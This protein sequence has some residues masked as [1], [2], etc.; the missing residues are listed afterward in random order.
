MKNSILIKIFLQLKMVIY[1]EACESGS[2]FED[3][4]SNTINV[5][6]TTASNAHESSYACYYDQERG[7]YLGD[8]YSIVWMEDSDTEKI[9]QETLF[10]QY[11]ITKKHT[12]TSHVMEFGDFVY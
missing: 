12:N 2:M 10:R 3:I 4:L 8:V 11:L 1:M 6:A 5:Y 7:T 9:D